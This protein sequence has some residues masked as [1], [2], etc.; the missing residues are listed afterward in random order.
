MLVG[1]ATGMLTPG[2]VVDDTTDESLAGT[3]GDP[4]ATP[5]PDPQTVRTLV[6][7]DLNEWR[8][9]RGLERLDRA[10]DRRAVLDTF[11]ADLARVDYFTNDS[12][13]RSKYSPRGRLRANGY[14]C[15]AV[16]HGLVRLPPDDDRQT[17]ADY[18]RDTVDTVKTGLMD[19]PGYQYTSVHAV[20]VHVDD[21]T[22]YVV[23]VAC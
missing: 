21:G 20:G 6:T 2:P 19:E 3:S 7:E 11:A 18:A 9:Q 13:D 1:V 15:P 16:A 4:T 5:D 10:P 17:A 14:D 23:Y 8:A 12:V 22:V